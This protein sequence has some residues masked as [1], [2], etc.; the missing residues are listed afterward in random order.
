MGIW[1]GCEETCGCRVV[2][3][4]LRGKICAF[5]QIDAGQRSFNAA[6]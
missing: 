5:S 3:F 4:F 1:V 2:S 6:R